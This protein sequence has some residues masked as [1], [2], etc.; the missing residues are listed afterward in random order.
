MI[1]W[2]QEPALQSGDVDELLVLARRSDSSF[3][4]HTDD[5]ERAASTAYALGD[6]RVPAIG[7][8]NG[9]IYVITTAGTTGASAP[10]WPTDTGATVTDGTAVWT[11]DGDSW[12][13][14]YDLNAGAAEGWRWKAALVAGQFDFATDQQTFNRTGKYKQCI[15]MAEHYG[16]RVSGSLRV[17]GSLPVLPTPIIPVPADD[18]TV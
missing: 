16:K 3:R 10:V 7:T 2:D 4:W 6:R 17:G 5:T 11:E 8:R 14:T 1:A 12:S 18:L 15:S 13:P 9:H